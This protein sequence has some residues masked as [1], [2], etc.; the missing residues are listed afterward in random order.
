MDLLDKIIAKAIGMPHKPLSRIVFWLG[1]IVIMLLAAQIT[2]KLVPTD[3]SV[4]AWSPTPVNVKD[5]GQVD[6]AGLQ[7]LGL[8]GKADTQSDRPKVAAVETIT[9][10][11]KTSLSIQLTGVVAS[12]TDQKGLAVI[13]SNGSQETYSL[14]DKIKG[15]SASLKEVYADRIIITN[16]GRY[17][18]LMLDGLVY[19]SQSPANQQLQQAKSNTTVNRIDQ[20]KNAEV[21]QELAE[22]RTELLADPSKITDYIAISPVRQ[23]DAVAGY[24]L[25]PGKDANLF[26]QA[27]FKA[28]DLAKSINGYDLTVMSQALEMMS[29]LSELTEVSIMVEREGQ[30]VEIMFS[31]PQ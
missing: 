5:V 31:L 3:S 27:G 7:Q 6:L 21:S 17:E 15:T 13:E 4:T 22:S 23:G 14:G 28:N 16:A 11:P 10:A 8:F 9:D 18:T 1:F 30:L 19:T 20:R 24:R 12:T 26:K 29:Q 25:N 2:W